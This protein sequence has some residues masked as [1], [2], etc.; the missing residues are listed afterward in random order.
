MGKTFVLLS[1][2][3]LL[4]QFVPVASHSPCTTM[5]SVAPS[6]P[7]T[8]TSQLLVSPL[9]PSLPQAQQVHLPQPLL[10]G[11][12]LEPLTILVNLC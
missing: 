10:T 2:V 11:K 5:N 12:V 3:Y 8:G 9:K 7:P 6:L 1:D 4:F